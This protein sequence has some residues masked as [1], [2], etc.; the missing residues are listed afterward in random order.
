MFSFGVLTIMTF[1]VQH[2]VHVALMMRN[3]TWH[4]F[5]FWMISLIQ[6]PLTYLAGESFTTSELHYS[7]SGILWHSGFFW[8]EVV[9]ASFV[10]TAPLYLWKVYRSLYREPKFLAVD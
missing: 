4:F 9:L 6:L 5:I 2:H 7:V 10:V 1:V 3:W 8:M